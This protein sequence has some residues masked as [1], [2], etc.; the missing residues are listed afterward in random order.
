M[1]AIKIMDIDPDLL[2]AIKYE[3][4]K[5][6]ELFNQFTLR[7][8]Y[9]GSCHS[10]TKSIILRISKGIK[11][12]STLDTITEHDYMHE[13]ECS[14]W[15]DNTD[16]LESISRLF[17]WMGWIT[18]VSLPP[19]KEITPHPD[20]GEYCEHYN[21]FHIPLFTK[22]SPMRVGNE[23]FNMKEG[24][25]WTFNNQ[26]VHSTKNDTDQERIHLIFDAI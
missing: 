20:E 19:G 2:G 16:K 13:L 6:Y 17:A 14:N 10:D 15:S 25:L 12:N 21:R 18:I 3:V 26:L 5:N 4:F 1:K 23:T 24:E 9:P 22:N 7:Q 11:P 8:D